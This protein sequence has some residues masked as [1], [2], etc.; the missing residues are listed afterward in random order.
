MASPG[1]GFQRW[2][3]DQRPVSELVEAALAAE[4][5][6]DAANDALVVLHVRG[7]REVLDAALAL[8]ASNDPKRRALAATIL[9]QLGTPDRTFPEECRAAL[10]DLVRR[11]QEAAVLAA[12]VFALGHR[13]KPC[14]APELIALRRH[15]SDQIRRAVARA[16]QGTTS[17]MGVQTLLELMDDPY[18]LARDWAT[19]GI[20]MT[21][22]L[23]GPK[24]RAALLR[25]AD[26]G[27]EWTRAEALHGLA[28]RGDKRVVPYLRTELSHSRENTYL[29]EYAAK[30][31]LGI[32]EDA[33]IEREAL[34]SRLDGGS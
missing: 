28:R 32:E 31:Y 29:F 8:R 3:Q 18:D 12:A 21:V 27:D 25:R 9:G 13:G 33:E 34:I 26:D 24:I 4:E 6:E 15:P 1:T 20:G 11:E 16:L 23:D 22:A 5:E 10:L 2:Q 7:T 17:E 19:T 14:D 30:T